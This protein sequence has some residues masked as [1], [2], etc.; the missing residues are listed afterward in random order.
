MLSKKTMADLI[1]LKKWTPIIRLMQEGEVD[2]PLK[3]KYENFLSL[4]YVCIRESKKP[5][6]EFTYSPHY[7]NGSVFIVK[8]RKNGESNQQRMQAE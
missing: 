3:F 7:S 8:S 4:K 5:Q 6:S 2:M 1:R